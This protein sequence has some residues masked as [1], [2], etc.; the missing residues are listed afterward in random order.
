MLVSAVPAC[1]S[2]LSLHDSSGCVR[3]LKREHIFEVQ[4]NS[5]LGVVSGMV[6]VITANE[7]L[8]VPFKSERHRLICL[9]NL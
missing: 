5:P 2:E 3:G 4:K 1:S 9:F 6:V 7:L 8:G